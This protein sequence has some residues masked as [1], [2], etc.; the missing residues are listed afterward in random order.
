MHY[1]ACCYHIIPQTSF[2]ASLVGFVFYLLVLNNDGLKTEVAFPVIL[3]L[4][5]LQYRLAN[6]PQSLTSTIKGFQALKKVKAFLQTKE[7]PIDVVER[8][9]MNLS[10]WHRSFYL[11]QSNSWNY[12][13]LRQVIII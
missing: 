4:H 5:L 7:L 10:K 12:H 3:I 9:N 11:M 2:Q 1:A 13:I 8:P 6:I